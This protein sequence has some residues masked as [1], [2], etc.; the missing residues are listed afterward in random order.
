MHYS[1]EFPTGRTD[2]FLNTPFKQ[3]SQLASTKN[4]V[5]IT[6]E[7]VHQLYKDLFEP[8][9]VLTIPPGEEHKSLDNIERLTQSLMELD[10]HKSSTIVAVGGGVVSD[11]VG[12]LSTIYMRGVRFGFV[13]TTLLSM[14]DA[15]IGGKNGINFGHV[16]NMIGTISQPHFILFDNSFLQS[17]AHQEWSNG[18]AEIIKYACIGDEKLYTHLQNTSLHHL[19]T[20]KELLTDLIALCVKHK[21]RIVLADEQENNIRK[22][23]NFGHTAGHAFESL[24]HLDHGQAVALGMIVALIASEQKLHLPTEIRQQFIMLLKQYSLATYLIFDINAVLNSISHDKKR[25]NDFIDFILI[26]SIGKAVITPLS[27]DEIRAALTI[28]ADEHKS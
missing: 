19:Q 9:T 15:S 4:T 7:N 16:K 25:K 27:F 8:Y 24:Y 12:F 11:L 2:F 21:T 13:P 6:D 20:H 1:I 28:F 23:L 5:I 18:F 26:E 17:L 10:I 3:L 22:T 14:V